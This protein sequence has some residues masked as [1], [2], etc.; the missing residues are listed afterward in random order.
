MARALHTLLGDGAGPANLVVVGDQ[1]STDGQF[2]LELGCRFALV[3]T[4]NT[5]PG[6]PVD[7][8]VAFDGPDFAAIAETIVTA[9]S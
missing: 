9:Q 7:F 5:P 4:G 8:D 1:V 6:A 3:R 2:A